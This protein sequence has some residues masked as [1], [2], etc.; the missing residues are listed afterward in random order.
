MFYLT[1]HSTHFNIWLYGIKCM[2]KD[3]REN[4][5]ENPLLPHHGLFFPII[6]KK[7]FIWNIPQTG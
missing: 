2:V 5:S 3:H 6:I 1:I 7:S 4:D